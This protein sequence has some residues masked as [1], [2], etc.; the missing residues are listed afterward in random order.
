MKGSSKSVHSVHKM[1]MCICLLVGSRERGRSG[2][3]LYD[4]T[5]DCFVNM[6]DKLYLSARNWLLLDRKSPTL[7]VELSSPFVY[8]ATHQKW[9][10]MRSTSS[11]SPSR[12]RRRTRNPSTMASSIVGTPSSS[13]PPVRIIFHKHEITINAQFAL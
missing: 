3:H 9:H 8:W 5:F 11:Q 12:P 6:T 2:K 13:D 4:V 1:F 7:S 10:L